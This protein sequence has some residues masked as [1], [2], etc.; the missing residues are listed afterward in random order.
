MEPNCSKYRTEELAMD[1]SEIIKK[2][3]IELGLSENDLANLAGVTPQTVEAVENGRAPYYTTLR[4]FEAALDVQ[5]TEK[6][7]T[8]GDRVRSRRAAMGMSQ[9]DL[10]DAAGVTHATI[11]RIERDEKI[12]QK[13]TIKKL[14]TALECTANQLVGSRT[15]Y[16]KVILEKR[17]ELGYSR[18]KLSDLSGVSPATIKEIES[19]KHNPKAKTVEKLMRVLEDRQL[20]LWD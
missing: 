18:Q 19:K 3:R 5:L 17:Q 1:V 12:P 11:C 2:R 10:A 20:S 4:S 13:E 8:L 14:A 16:A 9:R 6:D 7:S 15:N